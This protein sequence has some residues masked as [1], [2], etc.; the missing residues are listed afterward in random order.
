MAWMI[1]VAFAVSSNIDNLGVGITYGIRN[2]KIRLGSN[3]LIAVICFLMSIGGITI[4]V[5][6]SNILP[7]AFPLI[8]GAFLLVVI[9]LR[10]ILLAK[11]S[12]KETSK[13]HVSQ[14]KSF[15]NILKNPE[16]AD[17][18]NS[19]DI[20][21][22]EAIVLGIALSANTITNGVGAGLLG[23]S[24]LA[25]SITAAIGSLVSVWLGVRLGSKVA[26]VRI[27]SFTVGQFGTVLSGVIIIIIAFTAFSKL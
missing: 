23:L 16:V 6:L 9:G 11:P 12:N 4:G 10:I 21:W 25:I 8:F 26:D 19:G 15:N 24:P 18:D 20:G 3:T 17:R 22:G 2:I 1:I 27:G 14:S 7:G 13:G 5:W